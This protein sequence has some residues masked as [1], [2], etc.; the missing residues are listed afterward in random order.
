MQ[1]REPAHDGGRRIHGGHTQELDHG[2][3][4]ADVCQSLCSGPAWLVTTIGGRNDDNQV[5]TDNIRNHRLLFWPAA[6]AGE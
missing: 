4:D 3:F 2:Y 6:S 1:G 5:G